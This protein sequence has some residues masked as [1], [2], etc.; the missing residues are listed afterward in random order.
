[1]YGTCTRWI[2]PSPWWRH[3]ME[4]FSTLLAIWAGNSPVSGEFPAQRPVTRSFEVFFDLHRNKRFSKQWRGWWFETPSCPLWRHRN[5]FSSLNT[6]RPGQNGRHFIDY[7]FKCIF[8]YQ[9]RLRLVWDQCVRINWWIELLD[10]ILYI[11]GELT[12][13]QYWFR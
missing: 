10:W 11:R 7:I 3:Q 9:F 5:A 4:P 8:S 13:F 2:D 1:M 6:L 12:I